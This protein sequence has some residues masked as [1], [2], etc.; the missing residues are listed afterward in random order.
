[1]GEHGKKGEHGK[2]GKH[3]PDVCIKHSIHDFKHSQPKTLYF[4]NL[5]TQKTLLYRIY[6]VG[7]KNHDIR[8]WREHN[9]ES[10]QDE[11]TSSDTCATMI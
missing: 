2:D 9:P 4:Y 1:M 10:A 6:R 5:M 8:S 11:G 3:Q 7:W